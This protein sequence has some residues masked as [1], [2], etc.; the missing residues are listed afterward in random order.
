M[1]VE[2]DKEID[3]LLQ[4]AAGSGVLVGDDAKAHLDADTIVA[5][6]ENALPQKSRTIYTQ[7][8]A[9]CDP[10]RMS[11]ANLISMNAAAEPAMAAAAAPVPSVSVPWYRKFFQAPNIAYVMGGLVLIF[12]GL[13]GVFVLQRSFSSGESTLSKVEQ[14]EAAQNAPARA[15]AANSL[16][17]SPAANTNSSSNSAGEIPHS[18]GVADQPAA[19]PNVA[20]A[21]PAAFSTAPSGSDVQLAKPTTVDS[22]DKD[23]AAGRTIAPAAA[24]AKE[25]AKRE[26]DERAKAKNEVQAAAE[27]ELRKQDANA[28]N[29]Y[30]QQNQAQNMTPGAGNK[31]AGPNRAA[32]QRDNRDLSRQKVEDLPINGRSLEKGATAASDSKSVP[33]R[34]IGGKTFELKQG[35]WYDST[36]SGHPTKNVQRGTDEFRKLD[37]G[38]RNIA[39]SISGTVVVV[40]KGKAYRIQ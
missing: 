39:N 36:Y 24:P 6:A 3:A 32:I 11:L 7:H 18:V 23:I 31:T 40:W 17:N 20:S 38:L 37:S 22:L 35:A 12:G 29:L 5:F 34:K 9:A 21:P 19:E 4:K 14:P 30:N 33:T 1:D 28:T 16:S 13:L 8:L 2:F 27:Q 25:E 10:C 26:D 15:E